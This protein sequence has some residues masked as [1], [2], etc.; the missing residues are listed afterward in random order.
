MV[1]AGINEIPN[2]VGL[3]AAI[4]KKESSSKY[5]AD[6]AEIRKAYV[7]DVK[8]NYSISSISQP[9]A[10]INTSDKKSYTVPEIMKLAKEKVNG[11]EDMNESKKLPIWI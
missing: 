8:E 4:N 5:L 3:I 7:Q 11:Y 10:K 2:L 1:K 9:D 6:L